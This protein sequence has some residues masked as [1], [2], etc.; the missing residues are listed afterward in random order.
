M[1]INDLIDQFCDDLDFDALKPWAKKLDITYSAPSFD[2]DW[3][4]WED[5]LRVKLAEAMKG[6]GK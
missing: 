4:D 6:V 5:E 1:K 2:D 3:P